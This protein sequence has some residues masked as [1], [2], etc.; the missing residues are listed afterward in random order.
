M[1]HL[2]ILNWWSWDHYDFKTWGIGVTNFLYDIQPHYRCLTVEDTGALLYIFIIWNWVIHKLTG[3]A[4]ESALRMREQASS[5]ASWHMLF[6]KCWPFFY[7]SKI[8]AELGLKPLTESKMETP[9]HKTQSAKKTRVI[10]H[11][12]IP[13]VCDRVWK[14]FQKC[15]IISA[16]DTPILIT[17]CI[18]LRTVVILSPGTVTLYYAYLCPTAK[19]VPTVSV[20]V[21]L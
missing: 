15:I 21:H 16:V 9:T 8:R 20:K 5:A 17:A 13:I 12:I 19:V 14:A 11:P 4:A 18:S 7:C 3:L 1:L 2:I 6:V 10:L